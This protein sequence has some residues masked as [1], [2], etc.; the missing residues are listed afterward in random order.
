MGLRLAHLLLK[1]IWGHLLTCKM[2]CVM[3]PKYFEQCTRIFLSVRRGAS[4]DFQLSLWSHVLP[5]LFGPKPKFIT[6]AEHVTGWFR[7]GY[8]R[9][10]VNSKLNFYVQSGFGLA[11]WATL[12]WCRLVGI[13]FR[14]TSDA[15]DLVWGCFLGSGK[16]RQT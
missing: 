9:F 8:S 7:V 1:A 13:Y 12:D 15:Q 5:N 2:N 14:A 3:T 4:R 6:C 10:R 11:S 16:G